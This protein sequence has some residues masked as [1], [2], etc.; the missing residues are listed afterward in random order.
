MARL[1]ASAVF[2]LCD[3][4][5]TAEGIQAQLRF[6]TSAR[7]CTAPTV[8]LRHAKQRGQ[9]TLLNILVGQQGNDLLQVL[10]FRGS[11]TQVY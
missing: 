1:T 4:N 3:S 8:P 7:S 10:L 9:G 6:V 5:T 11:I 2:S